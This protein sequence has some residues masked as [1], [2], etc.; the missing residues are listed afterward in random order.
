MLSR[1]TVTTDVTVIALHGPHLS[2]VGQDTWLTKSEPSDYLH[3][4]TWAKAL[5]AAAPAADGLVYRCRH[6]ED[7]FAWMLTT[8]PANPSHPAL[9]IAGASVDLNSPASGSR[10]TDPGALQRDPRLHDLTAN[11]TADT[12]ISTATS[13]NPRSL[14][15]VAGP[16]R[17]GPP[18]E[19]AARCGWVIDVS[20][21]LGGPLRLLHRRVGGGSSSGS[22]SAGTSV[23]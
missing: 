1:L 4:R 8:D 19:D 18:A 7:Q 20:S 23:S 17:P 11:A 13:E 5:F 9:E 12:S 16:T 15:A 21:N 10:R 14:P 22:V 2:A 3:T 6:N